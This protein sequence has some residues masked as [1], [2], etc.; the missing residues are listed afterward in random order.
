MLRCSD[1][2]FSKTNSTALIIRVMINKDLT[3]MLLEKV[4]AGC[5]SSSLPENREHFLLHSFQIFYLK[6]VRKPEIA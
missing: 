6:I 5:G 2:E 4:R 3:L 1:N